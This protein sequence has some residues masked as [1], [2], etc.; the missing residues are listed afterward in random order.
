MRLVFINFHYLAFRFIFCIIISFLLYACIFHPVSIQLAVTPQQTTKATD[1]EQPRKLYSSFLQIW[2]INNKEVGNDFT[3]PGSLFHY[4]VCE[5]GSHY[6]LGKCHNRQ[7]GIASVWSFLHSWLTDKS[8]SPHGN[9]IPWYGVIMK[10]LSPL[11]FNRGVHNLSEDK[12]RHTLTETNCQVTCCVSV[13]R[14]SSSLQIWTF[15]FIRHF[16]FPIR[17]S[18]RLGKKQWKTLWLPSPLNIREEHLQLTI[19]MS[20]WKKS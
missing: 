7:P 12:K 9:H 3:A 15:Y 8:L 11:M 4:T 18:R 5:N 14:L 6:I 16:G 2:N 1:S 17:S 19:S 20:V 10:L 13:W